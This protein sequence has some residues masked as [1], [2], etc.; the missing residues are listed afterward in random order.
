MV[1]ERR[2][3]KTQRFTLIELLFVIAIIAI[4]ASL[5]LPALSSA[6]ATA[7]KISCANNMNMVMKD[8]YNYADD[9]N[10]YILPT[11]AMK[12]AA[13]GIYWDRILEASGY[14]EYKST[15]ALCWSKTKRHY[16]HCPSEP[17]NDSST[18]NGTH[19]VDYAASFYT[20]PRVFYYNPGTWPKIGQIKNPS[21]RLALLDAK[22]ACT[23]SYYAYNYFGDPLFSALEPRHMS[24]SNI[25]FE[26]GH[27]G[28]HKLRDI[29]RDSSSS[30]AFVWDDSP[31]P[32]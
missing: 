18:R 21:Q 5:L 28:Y 15:M 26:D 22:A 9:H 31:F 13:Q 32:W 24:G 7:K 14:D 6:K 12:T 16:Y 27:Y 25:I 11:L 3:M 1:G 23:S 2:K 8:F 29:P 10:G 17:A 4:L 30:H 20:H 19:P